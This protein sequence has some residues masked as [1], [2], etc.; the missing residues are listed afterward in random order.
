MIF[1]THCHLGFTDEPPAATWQR[2]E[3]AA[4]TAI[5]HDGA[6]H[7]GDAQAFFHNFEAEIPLRRIGA[8]VEVARA[9]VFLASDAAAYISGAGLV[10]DGGLTAQ[11]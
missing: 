9:I 3:A 2:A 5:L 4:R 11:L 10:V 8:P 6:R 1:D 7:S